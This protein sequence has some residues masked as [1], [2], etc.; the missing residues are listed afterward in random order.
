MGAPVVDRLPHVFTTLTHCAHCGCRDVDD[1]AADECAVRLRAEVDRLTLADR[2]FFR[3]AASGPNGCPP[4]ASHL[5]TSL[6]RLDESFRALRFVEEALR[7]EIASLTAERDEAQALIVQAVDR[8]AWP[9]SLNPH[10]ERW[11][12]AAAPHIV[13]HEKRQEKT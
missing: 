11:L 1:D 12:E 3:W 10:E 13:A 7:E 2:E 4:Y 9:G 6:E 5:R 8:L